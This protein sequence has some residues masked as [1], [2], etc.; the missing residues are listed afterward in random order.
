MIQWLIVFQ[1]SYIVLDFCLHRLIHAV[2]PPLQNIVVIGTP[3]HQRGLEIMLRSFPCIQ[4]H[5]TSHLFHDLSFFVREAQVLGAG[6]VFQTEEHIWLHSVSYSSLNRAVK[7]Q[8]YYFMKDVLLD[9]SSSNRVFSH[10]LFH[11]GLL[12]HSHHL[13]IDVP[14]G[15]IRIGPCS[16][17]VHLHSPSSHRRVSRLSSISIPFFNSS[18]S[19]QVSPVYISSPP[20]SPSR[21]EFKGR[22]LFDQ[23]TVV[24]EASPVNAP[25]VL[26]EA[27][28]ETTLQPFR[29][30]SLVRALKH[31]R[32]YTP[33]WCC[34]GT[35]SLMTLSC[36]LRYKISQGYEC[37]T[38]VPELERRV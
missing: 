14:Q 36:A 30:R 38:E 35:V 26:L 12:I 24:R 1:G 16:I 7:H 32:G 8:E 23:P 33:Y 29:S 5:T 2:S 25:V 18:P 19:L 11:M 10:D 4:H 15:V 27:D 37:F 13:S 28:D 9:T 34:R 20:S 6:L 21:E 3:E 31:R 17:S 22:R